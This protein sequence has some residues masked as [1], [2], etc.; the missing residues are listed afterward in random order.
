MNAFMTFLGTL[1]G[2]RKLIGFRKYP[3]NRRKETARKRALMEGA[4]FWHG[5]SSAI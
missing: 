4:F 5:R 2:N 1:S 3:S